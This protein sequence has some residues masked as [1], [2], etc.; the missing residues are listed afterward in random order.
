MSIKKS[1]GHTLLT[2]M[3]LGMVFIACL[4]IGNAQAWADATFALINNAGSIVDDFLSEQPPARQVDGDAFVLY[5]REPAVDGKGTLYI[6]QQ[7]YLTGNGAVYGLSDASGKQLLPERYQGI[8]VLPAA[9]FLN[10]GQGWRLYDRGTLQPLG[11]LAWDDVKLELSENGLLEN[12]LIQVKKDGL[13]GAV[14]MR[15]EVVIE[16]IYEEFDLYSYDVGWPLIRVKKDGRYGYIDDQ[17]EVVI[18]LS[19]DYA[20]L[21]S[22]TVYADENDA[23][24]EAVPI[25]Y[26]R[27]GDDWGG[28]LKQDGRPAP[29]DWDIEPSEE[30]LASYKNIQNI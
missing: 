15:G 21:S 10:Q 11:D 18:D 7:F 5:Y 16:P 13:Y 30:A 8:L 23:E 12:D 20:V 4:S 27:L 25:V 29:V 28:I 19:Y 6:Y 26:V 24:G 17:G 1:E 9:Y 14:N 2:F 3:R 22:I